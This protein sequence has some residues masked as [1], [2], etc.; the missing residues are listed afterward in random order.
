MAK[1]QVVFVSIQGS[2]YGSAPVLYPGPPLPV[3]TSFE[4]WEKK[5]LSN[6]P[7]ISLTEISDVLARGALPKSR[8]VDKM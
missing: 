2:D 7:T 8:L 4:D 6:I 1:V 3:P 5:L